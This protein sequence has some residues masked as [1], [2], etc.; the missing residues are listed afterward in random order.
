M[1]APFA[2]RALT[3][4]KAAAPPPRHT[5]AMDMPREPNPSLSPRLLARAPHRL[6]F[7]IGASN[8]L[9]AMAWWAA[10][11]ASTRWHW[12]VIPQPD[13]Y[14]GWLHAFVMQYQVL[15]SFFFGFL[16][17]TFP[18][19]MGLPEL[20]RWRYLPV[21]IGM[22]GGQLATLLGAFG[23]SGGMLAGAVLTL[24]GWCAGLAA[25]GPLLL[26]EQ[27]T[28]WHARSC[29]AALCLGLLGLLAWLALLLGASPLFAFASIKIG[30]FGL[31]LPVFVTVAHRMFPFFAGN[32][33]TGYKPWRPLWLLGLC[34][35]LTL[36]HLALELVH[37]YRWLWAP[38]LG[39]LALS[40]T[41]LW[42]WW[43]RGSRNGLLVTLFIGL[44]W[45]PIAFALYALQSVAYLETGVFRL[46]RAPAHA[47]FIGVFA[48]ILVAM[49]TRVTQGHS[50]RPLKMPAVAWFA[51]VAIQLVAILRIVAELAPDPMAWMAIAAFGWLLAF[52]PWVL[53][54]GRIYLSPRADGKP[55]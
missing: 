12:F 21:G 35:A 7:F 45:L 10:W 27:G 44:A 5:C 15:P 46:G 26:R 42:R 33:V 24:L 54:I 9:L 17:T 20:A 18:R 4:I 31:L 52:T 30:T 29:F 28:T 6:M 14:A 37:G 53:R 22:F 48:S 19:W 38:D 3:W 41:L 50:G 40:T 2:L 13:P 55:G 1:A 16:L 49:V 8:L 11:L 47:M 36:V 23:W 39:L 51:F 34:W 25:L 32:V 43:P